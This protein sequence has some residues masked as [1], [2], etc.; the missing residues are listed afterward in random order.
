MQWE[1]EVAHDIGKKNIDLD[2]L[3]IKCWAHI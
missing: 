2:N 1:Q 3:K